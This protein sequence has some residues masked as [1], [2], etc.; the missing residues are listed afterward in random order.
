MTSILYKVVRD[1]FIPQVISAPRFHQRLITGD[2]SLPVFPLSCT[3][4][5]HTHKTF[6]HEFPL[7]FISLVP[8]QL[9]TPNHLYPH[10]SH[11]PAS[12]SSS[13]LHQK[14]LH[15]GRP[16]FLIHSNRWDAEIKERKSIT[17]I[18]LESKQ[19][20]N[21]ALFKGNWLHFNIF[22]RYLKTGTDPFQLF[23]FHPS[24]KRPIFRLRQWNWETF[25]RMA[26]VLKSWV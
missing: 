15:L 21:C 18:F 11:L 3:L 22:S 7:M 1:S 17:L 19:P 14:Y 13:S 23:C 4:L 8:H 6:T 26:F 16:A 9:P 20:A 10:R 5:R 25:T 12:P 24:Q 2:R